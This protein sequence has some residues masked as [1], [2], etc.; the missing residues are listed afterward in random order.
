VPARPSGKGKLSEE[1]ASEAEDRL[2]NIYEF[3]TYR[4][5]NTALHQYKDQLINAV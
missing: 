1:K 5:E 3:G 4:K 2:N